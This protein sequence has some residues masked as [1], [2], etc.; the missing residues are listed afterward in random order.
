M[1]GYKRIQRLR[2]IWAN[3]PNYGISPSENIVLD[4]LQSFMDRLQ[5]YNG[6]IVCGAHGVGKTFTVRYF[7]SKNGL[8]DGRHYVCVNEAV[9]REGRGT[10]VNLQLKSRLYKM[11]DGLVQDIEPALILDGCEVLSLLDTRHFRELVGRVHYSAGKIVLVL[12]IEMDPGITSIT[13]YFPPLNAYDYET[14]LQNL[15]TRTELPPP[16]TPFTHILK[17][18]I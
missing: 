10:S 11:I 5:V 4:T 15:E 14:V 7:L 13:T 3:P 18:V 8:L 9:L 17:E 6:M 2:N 12:P 1:N 16:S